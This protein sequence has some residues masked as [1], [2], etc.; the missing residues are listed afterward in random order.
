LGCRRSRFRRQRE[1]VPGVSATEIKLGQTMA[2]SDKGIPLSGPG[3]KLIFRK[4]PTGQ[5]QV[6]AEQETERKDKP[7][8]PKK[9][10]P[11]MV[12]ILDNPC[13]EEFLRTCLRGETAQEEVKDIQQGA[14]QL[15]ATMARFL[16]EM[17]VSL[18]YMTEYAN[19]HDDQ[20]R[21]RTHEELR[22]LNI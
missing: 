3:A 17:S 1:D 11:E 20:P 9:N 15:S 4:K 21:V 16:T 10:K 18:R 12:D 5:L 14:A 13:A 7:E 19:I 22:S 8:T 2:Y 6:Q